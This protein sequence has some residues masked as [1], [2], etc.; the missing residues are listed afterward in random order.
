MVAYIAG[1]SHMQLEFPV[2]V[3]LFYVAFRLMEGTLSLGMNGISAR[4]QRL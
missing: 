2:Q 4:F 1:S 3:I